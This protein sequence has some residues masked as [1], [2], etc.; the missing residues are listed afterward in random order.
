MPLIRPIE[1]VTVSEQ[2]LSRLKLFLDNGQLKIGTKL[3]SER[4]LSLLLNVSRNSI[5]E[6][7][8]VLAVLGVIKS[9]HG[10]GTYLASSL[11][12]PLSRPAQVSRLLESSDIIDLW[13][14]RMAV[15]PYVA[16]LAAVRGKV[17]NWQSIEQTLKGMRQSLTSHEKF[18]DHD[19]QF[20]LQVTKAC[21]N[22]L[23]SEIASFLVQ[24]FW[25]K[26][27]KFRILDY[28][29]DIQGKHDEL[30]TFLAD[31][32]KILDALRHRDPTLARS[33]MV[34]HLRKVGEY[35]SRLVRARAERRNSRV[36]KLA[37]GAAKRES[38]VENTILA[39]R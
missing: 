36:K 21:G 29:E 39:E 9:S 32:E 26:C 35:D 18:Q 27:R 25:D 8:K 5:R 1:R 33:R 22:E 2:I 3:P 17:E 14:L 23:I 6:A 37:R 15:E 24:V 34:Q 28:A 10:K 13:E 16:S 4:Q 7:L 12:R 30:V 11:P 19:L 38:F 31:H 20:H